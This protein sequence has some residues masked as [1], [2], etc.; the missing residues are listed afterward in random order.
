M[1]TYVHYFGTASS[2]TNFEIY[3]ASAAAAITI[4]GSTSAET[5]VGSGY[6]DSIDPKGDSDSVISGN[7]ADTV[8][9]YTGATTLVGGD[10]GSAD[11]LQLIGSDNFDYTTAKAFGFEIIDAT[12]RSSPTS[13]KGGT[14]AETI[15]GG[16][17]SDSI[18]GGG[19]ADSIHAG[20]G[21]DTISYRTGAG[22]SI[23]GG[24]G[25]DV[26]DLTLISSTFTYASA[27]VSGIEVL[28]ARSR[29]SLG[30]TVIGSS[31]IDTIYGSNFAD[32]LG[33]GGADY[34]DAGLG[35]DSVLYNASVARLIGGDDSA[36]D[37]LVFSSAPSGG[38]V[39]NSS[40]TGFEVLDAR[41]V[42]GGITI[43]GSNGIGD[44]I[45]GGSGSDYL[46]GG[47]GSVADSLMGGDGA[48]TILAGQGV[49][50][51][52]LGDP[53]FFGATSIGDEDSDRVVFDLTN[54]GSDSLDWVFNFEVGASSQHGGN[55]DLVYLTGPSNQ[56]ADTA[57]NF[58]GAG[59]LIKTP[60]GDTVFAS[61]DAAVSYIELTSALGGDSLLSA[62]ELVLFKATDNNE[63]ATFI[64]YAGSASDITYAIKLVG[65]VVPANYGLIENGS[66][67]DVYFIGPPTG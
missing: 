10:D 49:D 35:S 42:T 33:N 27:S 64:G 16:S 51:V 13:L 4:L 60:S 56:V 8:V 32:S 50:T 6:G 52:W 25:N 31:G 61:L 37:Y 24:L 30:V 23:E 14:G 54:P 48:D 21:Q 28:D 58:I 55:G 3:D 11:V 41:L 40:I 5:I 43:T 22:G 59:G 12:A 38:F 34:I 20:A 46:D 65:V 45:F 7:G 2:V 19:G 57:T 9:F 26:L 39:V 47:T 67:S 1:L 36:V 44:T 29:S 63:T 62:G 17:G 15:Y 18:D 53:T 66:G